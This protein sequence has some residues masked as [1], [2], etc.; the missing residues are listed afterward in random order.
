M[1]IS[2]TEAKGSGGADCR[3]VGESPRNA[4]RGLGN[5]GGCRA[6][7]CETGYLGQGN[8]SWTFAQAHKKKRSRYT[9]E[10]QEAAQWG[11]CTSPNGGRCEQCIGSHGRERGRPHGGRAG[12]SVRLGC[13]P[14]GGVLL[15]LPALLA[16]GLL[17]RSREILSEAV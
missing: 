13:V 12:F 5:S 4:R 16:I 14:N 2:I 10:Q 8:R 9:A 11:G 7:G 3:G 1:T 17:H 6:I 15:A